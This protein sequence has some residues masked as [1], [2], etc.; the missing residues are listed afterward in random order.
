M[1]SDRKWPGSPL[2]AI[3]TG[4]KKLCLCFNSVLLLQLYIHRLITTYYMPKFVF[5]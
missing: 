3:E 4:G 5:N 2:A 1:L